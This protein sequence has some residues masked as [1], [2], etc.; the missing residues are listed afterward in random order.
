MKQGNVLSGLYR[1]TG[2]NKPGKLEKKRGAAVQSAGGKL[3]SDTR[4]NSAQK[5][6]VCVKKAGT[7]HCGWS[8]AVF[9]PSCEISQLRLLLAKL[10]GVRA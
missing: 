3:W 10:A 6:V 5:Y 1:Y 9:S 7:K 8:Q 2:R 4:I